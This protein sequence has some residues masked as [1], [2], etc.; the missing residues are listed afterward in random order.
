M[1]NKEAITE[2]IT[3]VEPD[4]KDAKQKE[5]ETSWLIDNLPVTIFRCDIKASWDIYYISKNVYDLTG[6]PKTDYLDKKLTWS[7]IVL[8]ED[9]P[10]I[11]EAIDIAMKN[12]TSYKVDY[13]VKNAKGDIVYI[14]EQAHLVNDDEGNAAYLDGVFLD[15]TENVIAKAESQKTIVKSIPEPALALFVD[16]EGNV[17]HINDYFVKLSQFQSEEEII[18]KPSSDI[19]GKTT[20]IGDDAEIKLGA[21]QSIIEIALDTRKNVD[22]LEAMVRVPGL[23]HELYTITSASLIYDEDGNFEGVLEVITDLTDVRQKEKEVEELLDYTNKCLADLGNGINMV[24]EGNLDVR[25]E[26]I[27]D[28][29]FGKIFDEF[30]DFVENLKGI[31]LATIGDMHT[32][33]EEVKQ[34][35]DAVNQMNTGMEQISTAAEQIATGSENLSRHANTAALDVKASEQIFKTLNE[36]SIKS[37][38]FSTEAV[39]MSNLTK[40]LGNNALEDLEVIVDEIKQLAAIVTSLD[41]AVDNIGKVTD[42]IQSIADQTNL[43]AL[44]AAIEAARAGE[45]GRG[46]A[47]VADE[48]RKLAEESRGSTAEINGIVMNVQKETKKVTEGIDRANKEAKDGSKDIEDALGKVSEIAEMVS[49]INSMLGELNQKSEEGMEKIESINEN[50]GEVASTAEENAAN[51]EETSAAIEEQT[52]A[53][54]QV[55]ASIKNVN[56]LAQK[57]LDMLKENFKFSEN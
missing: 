44:N 25:L 10:K 42:K 48:V 56:D 52:A 43:L 1:G 30:N 47:V 35:R 12:N 4:N 55:N 3:I 27:K 5:E 38:K 40:K 16:P 24:G 32:T 39:D 37:T 20:L 23:D 2:N 34:S 45:H 14:R 49:K 26:K 31:V 36:A 50:I 21:N 41:D 54:E 33:L 19:L 7:D 51:S 28:D 8:P 57:T 18:G 53:S 9:V 13:R 6:Y 22:S 29:D 17:K 15:I 46:F 11:D